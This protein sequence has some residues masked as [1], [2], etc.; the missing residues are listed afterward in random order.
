MISISF[1]CKRVKIVKTV[2]VAQHVKST[3]SKSHIKKSLEKIDSEY[4]FQPKTLKG[5]TEHS[6]FNG[7]SFTD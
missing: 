2:E 3:C 1:R 7:S 4:G 5:E 6:V